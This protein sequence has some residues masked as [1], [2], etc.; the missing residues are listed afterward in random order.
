MPTSESRNRVIV[1][2][3]SGARR[4]R[5]AK[6]LI[7]LVTPGRRWSAATHAKAPRFMKA[8]AME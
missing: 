7:W 3:R 8:Y 1:M 6:L 5:P 4:P 2:P